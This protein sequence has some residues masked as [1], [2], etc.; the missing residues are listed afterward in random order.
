MKN[1]LHSSIVSNIKSWNDTFVY[2]SSF[3][4]LAAIIS[5]FYGYPMLDPTIIPTFTQ[6]FRILPAIHFTTI[7]KHGQTIAIVP[8]SWIWNSCNVQLQWHSSVDDLLW[9]SNTIRAFHGYMG[10]ALAMALMKNKIKFI[11]F[12]VTSIL[13]K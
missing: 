13:I 12:P 4:Y 1:S 6:I 10:L 2:N 3:S 8:I 5:S 9:Q 7:F 11:I